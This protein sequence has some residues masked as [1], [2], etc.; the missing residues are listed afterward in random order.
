MPLSKAKDNTHDA[1]LKDKYDER[2]KDNAVF[3][4]ISPNCD[5]SASRIRFD[6]LGKGSVIQV[7]LKD[8]VVKTSFL[9]E[10]ICLLGST[11]FAQ[12]CFSPLWGCICRRGC[13]WRKLDLQFIVRILYLMKGV[14]SIM[15]FASNNIFYCVT[16][17]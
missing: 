15:V 7:I 9:L 4:R 6:C 10:R 16:L 5:L 13:T 12:K 11:D 14:F 8:S 2:T 3:S 1:R 17:K